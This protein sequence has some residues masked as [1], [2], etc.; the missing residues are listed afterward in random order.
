M[1]KEQAVLTKIKKVFAS[2]EILLQHSVLSYKIH[3]YFSKH[4]LATEID[5][6]S[7][8]DRNID[9]EIKDKKQ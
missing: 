2:K 7:H 9:Y 3:L 4:R 8:N 6:K 5:E 1:T